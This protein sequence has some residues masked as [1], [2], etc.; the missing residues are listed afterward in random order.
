MA[1]ARKGK[2]KK[3]A[4]F[5]K[6]DLW[7]LKN[8]QIKMIAPKCGVTC[9]R[10]KTKEMLIEE[11]VASGKICEIPEAPVWARKGE[12]KAEKAAKAKAKAEPVSSTETADSA[13]TVV[14]T[15]PQVAD[16][17]WAEEAAIGVSPVAELAEDYVGLPTRISLESTP[18][19]LAVTKGNRSFM[20]ELAGVQG[21]F[22]Y[23][24]KGGEL[25]IT[26]GEDG[27]LASIVDEPTDGKDKPKGS[28]FTKPVPIS[29]HE[30]TQESLER[31]S[32]EAEQI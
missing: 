30:I 26:Y 8:Q 27:T 14:A 6:A 15:H 16:T 5:T 4:G 17:S 1:K 19:K 29:R 10:T 32:R 22:V 12:R 7:G 2:G 11:I 23:R 3:M 25:I 21:G 18:R 31:Y 13:E 9:N 24:G 28:A 20:L